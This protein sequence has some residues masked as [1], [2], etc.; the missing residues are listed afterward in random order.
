MIEPRADR[1]N[2]GAIVPAPAD[3]GMG[4]LPWSWA[5]E[6]LERSRNY[7]LSTVNPGGTPHA[8]PV[9]GAWLDDTLLFSTST[10]SRKARNFA[11][12]PRCVATTEDASEAVIVEGRVDPFAETELMA[13]FFAEYER[14]YDWRMDESLGPFWRLAPRK[15]FGFIEAGD[16]F[17]QSATRWPFV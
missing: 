15:A 3:A 1:P 4:L 6:R 13:R 17:G 10:Q 5:R 7:W 14:K 16:A 9:W 2:L 11:R 12:Q 8:M